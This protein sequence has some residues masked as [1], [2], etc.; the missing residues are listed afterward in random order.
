M[1]WVKSTCNK[2]EGKTM[3][4][5]KFWAVA[6]SICFILAMYTGYKHK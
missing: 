4:H 3:K 6:A 2:K 5:H 1:K